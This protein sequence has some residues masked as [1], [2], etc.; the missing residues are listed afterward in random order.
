MLAKCQ[1]IVGD[2]LSMGRPCCG[3]F[4]CQEPLQNNRHR[5]CAVHYSFHDVCAVVNCENPV[6]E[7]VTVDTIDG[8]SK[9]T[10]RKT[11]SLPLHQQM[12]K[13]HH[14]R[15]TGWLMPKLTNERLMGFGLEN[16]EWKWGCRK[17]T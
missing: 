11:C 1:A 10:K 9:T 4:K 2:G 3:I 14:E 17:G 12:E 8:T 15:S 16:L 5:F 13:K 6:L 7:D